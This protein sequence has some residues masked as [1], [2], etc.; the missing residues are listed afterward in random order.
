[1]SR[2]LQ[3]VLTLA[4]LLIPGATSDL[5]A[6]ARFTRHVQAVFSRLGCNGGTC[7]GESRD[8]VASSCRSSAPNPV[9]DHERLLEGWGRRLNV[10][11]PDSSLL[12]RKATG[13][14]AHQGGKRTRIGSPEYLLLREWIAAGALLDKPDRSDVLSLIATPERRTARVGETYRLRGRG[15]L[16]RWRSH[17]GDQPLL[18]SIAR[19]GR[20]DRGQRWPGRRSRRG[21]YRNPCPLSGRHCPGDAHRPAPG[22]RAVSRCQAEQLHRPPRHRETATVGHPAGRRLTDDSTFLRRAS[23]DVTG[24]LPASDEVRR[25]LNDKSPDKRERKIDELLARPGY[26][27]LWTL[28]FCDLLKANDF[29]ASTPTAFAR[30]SMRRPFSRG[31]E[32]ARRRTSRTTSSWSAS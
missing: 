14:V 15:P 1:M 27:A 13:Q 17:G 18:V 5:Q 10:L 9:L 24:E 6:D 25:F 8:R 2:Y 30:R 11:D 29:S 20:R 28:K 16:Q 26:S 12:L 19:L 4:A 3:L 32:P 22:Q 31:F 23:L 21:R 7:H